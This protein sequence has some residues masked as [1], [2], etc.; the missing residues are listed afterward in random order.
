M[1]LIAA[2]IAT[3]LALTKDGFNGQCVEFTC[4]EWIIFKSEVSYLDN[5]NLTAIDSDKYFWQATRE[6]VYRADGYLPV[7]SLTERSLDELHQAII[8]ETAAEPAKIARHQALN[9]KR[10][11][12]LTTKTTK[13]RK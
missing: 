6:H 13:G 10:R 1:R 2:D 12:G 4:N 3:K 5:K 8:D 7:R 9:A 11:Q